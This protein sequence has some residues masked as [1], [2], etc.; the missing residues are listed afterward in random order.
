MNYA[1]LAVWANIGRK[2]MLYTHE[3]FAIQ[4]VYSYHAQARM[5]L[6][7]ITE[8]AIDLVLKFGREIRA[9]GAIFYVLGKREIQKFQTI[10]PTIQALEGVQVVTSVQDGTIITV[11]RNK[12]LSQIKKCK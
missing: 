5:G 4:D 7:G 9:K 6:R 8:E 11:Y 3:V 1:L 2:F 10:N 12:N